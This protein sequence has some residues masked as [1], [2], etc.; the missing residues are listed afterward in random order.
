MISWSIKTTRTVPTLLILKE[1][2]HIYLYSKYDPQKEVSRW[3]MNLNINENKKK[4]LIV[5]MG[6]GY[7]VQAIKNK[8]PQKDIVV[9]ELNHEYYEWFKKS[10]Q[11]LLLVQQEI[12][13]P[14]SYKSVSKKDCKYNQFI[15]E[16][17]QKE[18]EPIINKPLLELIPNEDLLDLKDFLVNYELR[19]RSFNIHED[20]M[21]LNIKQNILRDDKGISQWINYY[22]DYPMILVSAGPSLSK[23]LPLL[24]LLRKQKKKVI[25]GCVGTAVSPLLLAGIKPDF[26][27][28]A[29]SNEN[30]EQFKHLNDQTIPLFYLSTANAKVVNSFCG[31]TYI[32]WQRGFELAEEQ[33][34]LR[35]EPLLETGGSVATCLLEVM[36]K[37][38]P[39]S[40]ALVGQD[41][42][43]TNQ[44][45]HAQNT[46]ALTT[47]ITDTTLSVDN[48]H[49]DGKVETARGLY[50]FLKWFEQYVKKVKT[51]TQFWNCTE[52][53]AHI[54]GWIHKSLKEYQ[55]VFIK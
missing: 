54:H 34:Y 2:K 19:K 15:E 49:L 5:G 51:D 52:G 18:C 33:A 10:E 29:E 14:S 44:V 31:D 50:L 25:I 48:Y 36:V 17:S 35:S 28:Y 4:I 13:S 21:I 37:M 22:E 26:I 40:I 53:G 27:M 8:Y 7:H 20:L 43:F 9:W 46:Q 3:I 39:I 23:Q 42:A 16:F 45:S 32:T 38:N 1:N 30:F 24:S 55:Q 11:Y 6:L 12:L 47:K 41:L